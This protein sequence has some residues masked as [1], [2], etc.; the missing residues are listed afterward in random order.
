[1]FTFRESLL[2]YSC[3]VIACVGFAVVTTVL[4]LASAW[5]FV[6]FVVALAAG[7]ISVGLVSSIHL[8]DNYVL[9]TADAKRDQ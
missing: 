2:F 8:H 9:K 3:L 1:L 4:I 7:I 5:L 6:A